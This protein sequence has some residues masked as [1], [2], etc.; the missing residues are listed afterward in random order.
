M[1][2]LEKSSNYRKNVYLLAGIAFKKTNNIQSATR[3][4]IHLKIIN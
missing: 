4:V 3:I 2:L 1:T